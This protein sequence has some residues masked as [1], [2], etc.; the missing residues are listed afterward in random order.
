MN[1]NN[2]YFSDDEENDDNIEE[3]NLEEEDEDENIYLNEFNKKLQST[4]T[5]V[6]FINVNKNNNIPK[7]SNTVKQSKK[8]ISLAELTQKIDKE[9]ESSKPKKFVS[10]RVEEKNKINNDEDTSKIQF[11]TYK[12]QFEPRLP[13]Y[14]FTR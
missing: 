10:K 6:D 5:L 3:I 8:K 2:I 14:N 9:I 12:R 7:K 4:N 1:R 13:P 11:E